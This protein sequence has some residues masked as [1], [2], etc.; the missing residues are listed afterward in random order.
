MA[1]LVVP[2]R[3]LRL[4]PAPALAGLRSLGRVTARTS[5]GTRAGDLAPRDA[6]AAGEVTPSTYRR[7]RAVAGL[8]AIATVWVVAAVVVP[9][10]AG[11][12]GSASSAEV[13]TVG[14]TVSVPV[15]VEHGPSAAPA[16]VGPAVG[17]GGEAPA[18]Y[19]VRSGD[20]LWSIASRVRPES[21]PR[22][23]VTVLSE[24]LDG[25]VIHPGQRIDVSDL[26]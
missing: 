1:A 26:P 6:P 19:V 4:A 20:T 23:V 8:L 3:S 25:V 22:A 16:D 10:L 14:A 24:R 2:P 18:R 13:V 11:W 7:R 12:L 17:G 21:D 5:T 15:G 9:A